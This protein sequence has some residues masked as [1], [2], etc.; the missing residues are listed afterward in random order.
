MD[1]KDFVACLNQGIDN[2]QEVQ[3][4]SACIY[5]QSFYLEN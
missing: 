1:Q 4:R 2:I 5:K 3:Y